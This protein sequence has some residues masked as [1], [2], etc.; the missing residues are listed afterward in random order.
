MPEAERR[1][2]SW[3]VLAVW[4]G[5]GAGGIPHP[6]KEVALSVEREAS[7]AILTFSSASCTSRRLS[8]S[9]SSSSRADGRSIAN[10]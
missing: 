8:S 1:D 9:S 4:T 2:Q 10:V 7:N 6:R 3:T 5:T